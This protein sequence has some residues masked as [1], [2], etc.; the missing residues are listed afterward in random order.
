MQLE[1]RVLPHGGVSRAFAVATTRLERYV[2][3]SCSGLALLPPAAQ[4][5]I[6]RGEEKLIAAGFHWA[7]GL[8]MHYHPDLGS[9]LVSQM[10]QRI[11]GHIV[12]QAEGTLVRF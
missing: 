10:F 6:R 2:R 4:D 12:P 11:G 8:G 5:L 9:L 7:E 3:S 1:I